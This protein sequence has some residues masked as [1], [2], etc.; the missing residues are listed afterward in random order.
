MGF[1]DR[2]ALS[3]M[4]RAAA[5]SDRAAARRS[6]DAVLARPFDRLVVGHGA[7]IVEGAQQALSAAY[8]WLPAQSDLS[9][10]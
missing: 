10:A 6:V 5:F 2:I 9:T 7:P 4:I 3:R 8:G 1:Y